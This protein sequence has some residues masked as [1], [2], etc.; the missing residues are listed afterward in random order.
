MT[1][2]GA[3]R[4]AVTA[5]GDAYGTFAAAGARGDAEVRA[6]VRSAIIG[7]STI[8]DRSDHPRLAV[9]PDRPRDRDARGLRHRRRLVRR[10]RRGQRS[11]AL[12]VSTPTVEAVAGGHVE[13]DRRP[14]RSPRC[15]P[16]W[17]ARRRAPT[18][19]AWSASAA[20]ARG[21]GQGITKAWIDGDVGAAGSPGAT[22][23]TVSAAGTDAARA[24]ATATSGGLIAGQRNFSHATVAPDRHGLRQRHLVGHRLAEPPR[25]ADDQR[26]VQPR[27]G[28][29]DARAL[30]RPLLDRRSESYVT[31]NPHRVGLP[32][33][34]LRASRRSATSSCRATAAPQDFNNPTYV[35]KSYN[36]TTDTLTVD[37]HGLETATPSSTAPAAP[38]RSAA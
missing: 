32:R 38:P 13:R 19:S 3:S 25:R 14:S 9:Q 7:G 31:V 23:L 18:R 22:N 8:D 21:R 17:R 16:T 6:T 1:A 12:A 34:A 15:R 28:R 29:P 11:R 33:P 37:N 26:G 24:T 36:P 35:V 5:N 2:D 4:G 20:A 27:G 30:R 10:H